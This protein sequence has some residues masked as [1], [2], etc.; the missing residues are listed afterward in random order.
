MNRKKVFISYNHHDRA[1]A[2]RVKAALEKRGIQVTIDHVNMA[3]GASIEEFIESSIRNSD[4]TLSIVSNT[5]LRSAWVG[6]ESV[7]A[8]YGEKLGNNKR[9]IAC[10]I[11]ADF[12]KGDFLLKSHD[13][14][15]SRIDEIE[16]NI[17]EYVKRKLDT[18][19]LNGEKSRLYKLLNNLGDILKRLKSSLTLDVRA[20]EFDASMDQIVRTIK[21]V[22]SPSLRQNNAHRRSTQMKDRVRSLLSG[23][24]TLL[25][26]FEFE[27]PT[28]ITQNDEAALALTAMVINNAS[29]EIRV[30]GRGPQI[31]DAKTNH[32]VAAVAKA[33]VRGVRYRRILV[34]DRK[35]PQNGLLW[36]LLL[37]RFLQSSSYRDQIFL[38][39]IAGSEGDLNQQFQIVDDRWLHRTK[40]FYTPSEPGASLRAQSFFAISPS[41]EIK[42]E[43]SSYELLLARAGQPCTHRAVTD[44]IERIL[45]DMAPG[46][47]TIDYHWRDLLSV[48]DFLKNLGETGMPERGVRF[49]GCLMPHT[50]THAAA[51]EFSARETSKGGVRIVPLPFASLDDAIEQF[52]Q[53]RLD[54]VVVP[55]AN[56]RIGQI[57]PPLENPVRFTDLDH[58]AQQV[59][60]VSLPIEFVLASKYGN[61][62]NWKAIVAVEPAYLQVRSFL[63]ADVA[64]LPRFS[65]EDVSSNYHSASLV[66]NHPELVAVTTKAA[67]SHL[68]LYTDDLVDPR[69]PGTTAFAIYR[70]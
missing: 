54:Y 60:A 64:S 67:A 17:P 11:E 43:S 5:S 36:L 22:P 52:L 49:I 6:M 20:P 9:F 47:S 29:A 48:V 50:F 69:G 56:S 41:K 4:V 68:G 23:E 13:E 28:A 42:L 1:V 59:A 34:L 61:R 32:Y 7:T 63:P 39:I 31:V 37:E 45:N 33:I 12:F 38:H 44:V 21:E 27:G 58:R 18:I 3:A 55:V 19:D 53:E 2:D 10:Y 8:L 57:A 24:T 25:K 35:L 15:Q 14:I 30:I 70:H 62:A 26:K 16:K 40:R 51:C 46:R 66:Q 65:N